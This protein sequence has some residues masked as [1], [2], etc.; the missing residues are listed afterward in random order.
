[1]FD[2]EDNN[3]N[4]N[5]NNNN[6]Y[7]INSKPKQYAKSSEE[8]ELRVDPCSPSSPASAPP[9]Q[10][11]SIPAFQKSRGGRPVMM[12]A[13]SSSRTDLPSDYLC[14]SLLNICCG[15][16]IFG[17]IALIFSIQTIKKNRSNENRS[18]QRYSDLS[19]NFNLTA[20]VFAIITWYIHFS[21]IINQSFLLN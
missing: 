13:N 14:W 17:F 4:N 5:N 18:A 10:I 6:N 7:T 12:V 21:T 16:W 9:Y 11:S 20:S 1:M 19:F 15:S 3:S 2:K 8:L